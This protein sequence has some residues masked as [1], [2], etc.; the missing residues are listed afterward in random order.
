MNEALTTSIRGQIG[1]EIVIEG[2]ESN[3]HGGAIAL[4]GAVAGV[5]DVE[6]SNLDAVVENRTITD[7]DGGM[8]WLGSLADGTILIDN[9]QFRN[10][11]ADGDG[12]A[13]SIAGVNGLAEVTISNTDFGA[14]GQGNTAAGGGGALHIGTLG[15]GAGRSSWRN[16]IK[17]GCSSLNDWKF[18]DHTQWWWS[19]V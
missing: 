7:G 5:S 11:A 9:C 18:C 10:Q 1:N 2:N 15:N 17:C 13:I 19:L 6:L 3:N 12:G 14:I 8:L 4:V 16:H